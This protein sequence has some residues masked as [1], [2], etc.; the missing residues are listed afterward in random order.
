M[1]RSLSHRI[2]ESIDM[3]KELGSITP[4]LQLAI[5]NPDQVQLLIECYMLQFEGIVDVLNGNLKVIS[6]E[7]VAENSSDH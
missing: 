4:L 1:H 7:A 3:V 5:D 6:R 2:D